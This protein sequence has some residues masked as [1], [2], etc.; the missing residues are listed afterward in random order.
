MLHSKMQ[1]LSTCM[2][3]SHVIFKYVQSVSFFA[4]S[5]HLMF[6][7]RSA[8]SSS[9][10]YHPF[11][12][13]TLD[14]HDEVVDHIGGSNCSCSTAECQHAECQHQLQ[15]ER[16]P[17]SWRIPP[18]VVQR[19][20]FQGQVSRLLS[21]RCSRVASGKQHHRA[22]AR[23]FKLSGGCVTWMDHRWMVLEV[24]SVG[25]WRVVSSL[26]EQ[27]GTG[28]HETDPWK[29]V[30]CEP[31]RSAGSI[32]SLGNFCGDSTQHWTK[33]GVGSPTFSHQ[34]WGERCC[35]CSDGGASGTLQCANH[36]HGPST[37]HHY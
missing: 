9:R 11:C 3:R 24:H 23:S 1:V 4:T 36:G 20:E 17:S 26:S 7:F 37:H 32:G 5:K 15:D 8:K 31:D 25:S 21:C 29:C 19:C 14:S 27:V 35:L 33:L 28:V 6:G 30:G 22:V 18:W 16:L 13:V 10:D 12:L 34:S 2:H